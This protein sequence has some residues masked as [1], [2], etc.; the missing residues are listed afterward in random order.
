LRAAERSE[1]DLPRFCRGRRQVF[2]SFVKGKGWCKEA[3]ALQGLSFDELANAAAQDGAN[4][5]IGVENDHF[6]VWWFFPR[7]AIA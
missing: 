3:D 2:R 4:E 1:A 6:S 5:D 7:D